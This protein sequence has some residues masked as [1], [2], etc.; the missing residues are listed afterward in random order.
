MKFDFNN[1]N[2]I[3]TGGSSGIG[4]ALVQKLIQSGANVWIIARNEEKI[5]EVMN[6]LGDKKNQLNY[7]LANVQDFS[8]IKRI[9]EKLNY[10]NIKI[11][12][13]INSA[14]VAHPAE[15]NSMEIEQFHWL[16]DINYFGTVHCIKAFL[17]LMNS[18][19]FIVNISSMA[20][21]IGVYGYSAYGASK[22]AV[23]GFS[24]CLRSELKPKNIQVSIIFPPDTDTPQLEYESEFKPEITKKIA[25]SAKVMSAQKV[26]LEILDGIKKKQYI[27]IPGFESKLIY[28]LSNFLGPLVYPIMD[29]MV[30]HAMKEINHKKQPD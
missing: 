6:Q 5:L 3:V 18:G 20:G 12:G 23:R 28:H 17:P 26:A 1:K 4:L 7:F 13:L 16:M 2:I 21:V 29:F 11:D 24:D 15:F 10:E 19:S 27:I 30:F 25:G 8:E 14:G 9:S 22:F